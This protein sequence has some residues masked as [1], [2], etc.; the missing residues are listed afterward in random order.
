MPGS[1]GGGANGRSRC[2]LSL[3]GAMLANSS[4]ERF[5]VGVSFLPAPMKGRGRC[6]LRRQGGLRSG[7]LRGV[8]AEGTLVVGEG[9]WVVRARLGGGDVGEQDGVV[10]GRDVL[11]DL[12]ADP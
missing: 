4:S 8:R 12:G 3:P 7:G 2:G 10:A 5:M 6:V 9:A 1:S 11:V